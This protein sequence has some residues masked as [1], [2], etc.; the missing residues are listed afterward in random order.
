[1]SPC[2]YE[3]ERRFIKEPRKTDAYIVMFGE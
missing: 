2:P 1:M 3:I